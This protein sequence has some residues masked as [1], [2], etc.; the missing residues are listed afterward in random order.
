[1]IS[2]II[3]SIL[4]L[5]LGNC[6]AFSP[7][8]CGRP[9]NPLFLSS[10][11]YVGPVQESVELRL[12][13][14]FS[15]TYLEVINESH[16]QL[17]DESHFKVVIVSDGFQD[18]RLVQRHRL[19]N[20]SLMKEGQLPFHA[21]TITAKTNEEWDSNNSVPQSPACMGGH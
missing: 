21:L 16:G 15:P 20:A 1:M 6:K 3:L 2:K 19:V 10:S 11:S 5:L 13:E 7:A 4:V 9:K 8:V 17:E 14:E 12:K 18:K